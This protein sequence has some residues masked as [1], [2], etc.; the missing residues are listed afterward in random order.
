MLKFTIMQNNFKHQ[1]LILFSI[2]LLLLFSYPLIS[3]ANKA[4]LVAGIP[5]LFVYIFVVW[6]MAI[7]ILYRLADHNSKKPNE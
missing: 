7:I 5:L 3:I 6:I 2:L 4:L 1:K